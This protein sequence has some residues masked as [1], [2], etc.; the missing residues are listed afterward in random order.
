MG[1]FFKKAVGFF[2]KKSGAS[3]EK[4]FIFPQT[5]LGPL[6]NTLCATGK[7]ATD[8]DAD[9]APMPMVTD[10]DDNDPLR[11]GGVGGML[12]EGSIVQCKGLVRTL[13][14][15]DDGELVPAVVGFFV[16][17]T[18]PL[19]LSGSEYDAI[20]AHVLAHGIVSPSA[21]VLPGEL[22]KK[23]LNSILIKVGVLITWVRYRG[24]TMAWFQKR[25]EDNIARHFDTVVRQFQSG[26]LKEACPEYAHTEICEHLAKEA[27]EIKRMKAFN[28]QAS[29]TELCQQLALR[30]SASNR[31]NRWRQE[32]EE[33]RCP[34]EEKPALPTV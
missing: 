26:N 18:H 32:K 22:T 8:C 6:A 7:M 31:I 14:P 4:K 16:R 34:Q 17:A 10:D 29:Y 3:K 27:R 21:I 30:S 9:C 11:L 24:E 19:V 20:C 2:L 25:M 15:G 28:P 12:V 1:R 5:D 33:K 13:F 23:K